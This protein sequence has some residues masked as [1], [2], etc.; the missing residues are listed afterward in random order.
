MEFQFSLEK[1]SLAIFVQV[2]YCF[3]I[4]RWN[5]SKMTTVLSRREIEWTP[6]TND[7]YQSFVRKSNQ[8]EDDFLGTDRCHQCHTLF[9][10]EGFHIV[11]SIQEFFLVKRIKQS[12]FVVN[13]WKPQYLLLQFLSLSQIVTFT[14]K[15]V[16]N[17]LLFRFI[18]FMPHRWSFD[19]VINFLKMKILQYSKKSL[20]HH[21]KKGSCFV[22]RLVK[23]S[24]LNIINKSCAQKFV[25]KI[26]L[27]VLLLFSF[28]F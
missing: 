2:L 19:E 21:E 24:K 20:S 1:T 27:K 12:G 7:F 6:Q 22:L 10:K 3:E 11:P 26:I 9:K 4:R 25:G 14:L 28:P 5:H 23:S 18:D 13:L 15:I 8:E 17:C 16:L